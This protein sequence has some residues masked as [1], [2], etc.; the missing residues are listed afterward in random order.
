MGKIKIIGISVLLVLFQSSVVS[1]MCANTWLKL[2]LMIPFISF[3]SI[4]FGKIEGGM[5]GVA[6]GIFEDALSSSPFGIHALSLGI[7]GFTIGLFFQLVYQKDTKTFLMVVIMATTI[8]ILIYGL[9]E[10]FYSANFPVGSFVVSFYLPML[11][12][13][14]LLSPFIFPI[15]KKV[16]YGTD[17]VKTF[18]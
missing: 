10:S 14:V 11:V 4:H 12:T 13:H 9:V 5:F 6:S 17:K 15:L 1:P 8:T 3:L 18:Y 2:D 16:F 7:M